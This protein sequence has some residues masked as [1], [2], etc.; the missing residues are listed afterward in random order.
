VAFPRSTSPGRATGS[1][2]VALDDPVL[3]TVSIPAAGVKAPFVDPLWRS[4]A[5]GPAPARVYVQPENCFVDVRTHSDLSALLGELDRQAARRLH[6][7]AV[8]E[9]LAQG[10][11]DPPALF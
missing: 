2:T 10:L 3:A 5:I 9:G 6:A 1:Q 8:A 11:A 4:S 7:D